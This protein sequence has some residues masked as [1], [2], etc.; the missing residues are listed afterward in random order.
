M[1]NVPPAQAVAVCRGVRTPAVSAHDVFAL[2]LA[3]FGHSRRDG[4]MYA[5]EG[6]LGRNGVTAG[7]VV[8]LLD[9][10]AMVRHFV[11]DADRPL[12]VQ[13]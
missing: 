9:E 4:C 8:G 13:T 3:A 5:A 2:I 12:L 10:V 11:V 6:T 7:L 1:S